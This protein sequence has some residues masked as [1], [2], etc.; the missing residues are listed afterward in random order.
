MSQ[1]SITGYYGKRKFAPDGEVHP[2]KVQLLDEPTKECSETTFEAKSR[3]VVA[4]LTFDG[5]EAVQRTPS[6]PFKKLG[7]LSPVK[8]DVSVTDIKKALSKSSRINE[9]KTRLKSFNS[10]YAKLAETSK[11][12]EKAALKQFSSIEIPVPVSPI[13]Q[14]SPFTS[15]IKQTSTSR[16]PFKSPTKVSI[17]SFLFVFYN[18]NTLTNY[19]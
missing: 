5:D 15:P 9:L 17:I 4:K 18:S 6:V 13:K 1:G 12:P 14:A 7:A 3:R 19:V 11:T 2:N 16:S 10:N 8:K